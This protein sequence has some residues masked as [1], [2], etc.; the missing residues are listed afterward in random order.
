[1]LHTPT[2]EQ[3]AHQIARQKIQSKFIREQS[4][5]LENVQH[6]VTKIH[7]QLGTSLMRAV[8][9]ALGMQDDTF[10]MTKRLKALAKYDLDNTS[11]R[12]ASFNGARRNAKRC[13]D[14]VKKP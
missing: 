6:T 9:V 14:K 13:N 2:V 7:H 11:Y 10:N 8:K 4:K 1:M 5:D 3:M 12:R